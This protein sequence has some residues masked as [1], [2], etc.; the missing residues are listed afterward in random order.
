MKRTF[1]LPNL[2]P[3]S[4]NAI[5]CVSNGRLI[6]TADAR[7]WQSQ[8]FYRLSNPDAEAAFTELRETYNPKTQA[9]A[10]ECTAYYPVADFYTKKGEISAKTI[11]ETNWEKALI[12]CMFL[13]KHALQAAP[14]GC[15]NLQ[16]DDKYVVDC[17][18]FKRPTKQAEPRIEV[19][20]QLVAR[21]ELD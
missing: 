13:P 17:F 18:S 7:E 2:K 3:F 19:T 14:Y 4:V 9:I 11:D 1:V 6:K 8:V 20:I 16:L 21:P 15:K 5:N 10:V 12:D